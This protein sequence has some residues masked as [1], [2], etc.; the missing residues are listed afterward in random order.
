MFVNIGTMN[1]DLSSFNTQ[2]VTNM[3]SMFHYCKSLTLDLSSFNTSK[4]TSMR[5]MFS[6]CK[7]LTSLDISNFNTSNVTDMSW[8]FFNCKGLINLNLSNFNTSKVTNMS[9]MFN[10]CSKLTTTINI[11]STGV[12]NYENMFSNAAT[13]IGSQ[14]TVNYIADASTLVDNMIATKSSTSNVVK[15]SQI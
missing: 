3:S 8:M 9:S 7:S 13:N 1:L 6:D 11:M 2:N 15:G 10:Y 12:T 5:S 4:V 14:I